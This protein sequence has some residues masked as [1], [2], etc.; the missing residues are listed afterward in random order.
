M[1]ITD[2]FHP[3]DL[4]SNLANAYLAAHDIGEAD[5]DELDLKVQLGRALNALQR[6][7]IPFEAEK[8]VL[9]FDSTE[10]IDEMLRESLLAPDLCQNEAHLFAS[11]ERRQISARIAD[12]LHYIKA[13]DPNL[14]FLIRTLIGTIICLK[15]PEKAGGSV[16]TLT[17]LIWINP[18]LNWTVV[19][20]AEAIVHEYI[21]NSIFL[22]DAVRNV[23]AYP[24]NFSNP[25]A[26]VVSAI[27]K[28]PRPYDKAYHSAI[29]AK[30]LGD[31]LSRAHQSQKAAFVMAGMG[32]T[33]PGLLGKQEQMLTHT[34]KSL[35]SQI[36]GE[37]FPPTE[38][39]DS[40]LSQ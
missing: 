7:H 18:R 6:S 37:H 38:T 10:V 22:C 25:E 20:Y 3:F 40:H 5:P 17:G 28:I 32:Q 35:L 12:A 21:H 36:A 16:S 29:V 30:C 33:L 15:Q 14:E 13:V 23:F 2:R 4:K 24:I 8:V 19:E 34:G 1:A 27:L 39:V 26:L 31:F 9:T 11:E